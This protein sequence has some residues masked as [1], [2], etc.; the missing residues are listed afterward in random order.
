[1][2]DQPDSSDAAVEAAVTDG[3]RPEP[4]QRPAAADEG[5]QVA[6]GSTSGPEPAAPVDTAGWEG[7]A[8]EVEIDLGAFLPD[9][10]EW[11]DL[12][13]PDPEP[14]ADAAEDSGVE[15]GDAEVDDS[16]IG[17]GEVGDGEVDETAL[18]ETEVNETEVA[19]TDVDEGIDA[20]LVEGLESDLDAV[21]AA[22]GRLDDGTYGSCAVCGERISADLLASNPVTATC[23]AHLPLGG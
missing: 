1:M 12:E 6:V 23:A 8:T 18:D 16:A 19:E 20:D 11:V 2:V 4:G 5:E 21:S 10:V 13:G 7:E 14:P 9:G 22:L 15:M 17:R 3:D